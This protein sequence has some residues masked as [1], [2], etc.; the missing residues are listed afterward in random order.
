MSLLEL[1]CHVDDFW[2]LFAPEWEQ[3]LVDCW[4]IQPTSPMI[5]DM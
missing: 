4:C 2:M 5:G 3:E 1:F